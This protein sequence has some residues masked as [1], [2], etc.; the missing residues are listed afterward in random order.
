MILWLGPY[1]HTHPRH[2]RQRSEYTFCGTF[3][4]WDAQWRFDSH[5]KAFENRHPNQNQDLLWKFDI[6]SSQRGKVLGILG[7]YNLNA[8][9]LFGS[10]ESLLET[11]WFREYPKQIKPVMVEPRLSG[12]SE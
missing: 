3:V 7:D 2:F 10:E 5:E 4:E 8:F 9:S 6:P 11:M 12:K 1:V